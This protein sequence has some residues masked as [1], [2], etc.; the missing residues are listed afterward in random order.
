MGGRHS[1]GGLGG[2]PISLAP[3]AGPLFAVDAAYPRCR[4]WGRLAPSCSRTQQLFGFHGTVKAVEAKDCAPPCLSDL[5]PDSVMHPLA[6]QSTDFVTRGLS[7]YYDQMTSHLVRS[8]HSCIPA[9]ARGG[10][11]R[12]VPLPQP[13]NWPVPLPQPHNWRFRF[14]S[15]CAC[16]HPAPCRSLFADF[17]KRFLA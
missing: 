11:G 17:R 1:R 13:H 3:L 15:L 5:T 6:Q 16:V 12:P 4:Q 14:R 2:V 8:C 7:P 9:K 10:P